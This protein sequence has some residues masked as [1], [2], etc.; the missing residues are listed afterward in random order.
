MV[1]RASQV[2]GLGLAN[3]ALRFFGSSGG[4]P[5]PCDPFQHILAVSATV[6]VLLGKDE[7]TGRSCAESEVGKPLANRR[8]RTAVVSAVLPLVLLAC[9]CGGDRPKTTT[10]NSNTPP[11]MRAEQVD[12]ADVQVH[13]DVPRLHVEARSVIPVTTPGLTD[14]AT[15]GAALY[16]LAGRQ[17]VKVDS[18]S[19]RVEWRRMLQSKGTALTVGFDSVWISDFPHNRLQRLGASTGDWESTLVVSDNPE[20]LGVAGSSVWV[21]QHRGGTLAEVDPQTDKVTRRIVVGTR[22][23][24]GPSDLATDGSSVYVSI[25]GDNSV[26]KVDAMTGRTVRVLKPK[27]PSAM[28]CGALTLDGSAV[29]VTGCFETDWV[30][31]LDFGPGSGF[32][33]GP[34]GAFAGDGVVTRH[35]VWLTTY[36]AGAPGGASSVSALTAF[37]RRTGRLLG[38]ASFPGGGYAATVAAGSLWV[39]GFN[40]GSLTRFDLKDLEAVLP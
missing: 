31:R 29:W 24:S 8:L 37:D 25:P 21:A 2:A 28:P 32:S 5:R 35:A 1:L 11:L 10:A 16:G 23:T 33:V 6:P 20:G 7:Q 9:G 27:E 34:L 26:A 3:R 19:G 38:R 18:H 4:L 13:G 14:L 17:V 12:G 15:D 30:T 40:S 39:A 36:Y 22:G